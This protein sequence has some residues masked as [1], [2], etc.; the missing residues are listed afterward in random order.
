MD[1][2]N[3]LLL[4]HA[5]AQGPAPPGVEAVGQT[6]VPTVGGPE[7]LGL[8]REAEYGGTREEHEMTIEL[9]VLHVGGPLHDLGQLHVKHPAEKRLFCLPFIP[10]HLP[11][12]LSMV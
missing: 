10:S 5:G 12:S 8:V 3:P 2:V 4:N 1:G 11:L 9:Y 6:E 7:G